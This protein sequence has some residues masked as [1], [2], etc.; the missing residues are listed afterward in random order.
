MTPCK[1]SNGRDFTADNHINGEFAP[2]NADGQHVLAHELVHT[3]QQTGGAVSMLPQDD[4]GLEID[5][6]PRLEQEAEE[7]AQRVMSGGELG[8]QRL[9]QTEVHIQ[10]LPGDELVSKTK[11]LVGTS[12]EKV[13]ESTTKRY[14]LTKDQ[15]VDLVQSVETP[16]GLAKYIEYHDIDVTSRVQDASSSAVKGAT[17]GWT[18]GSMLGS[19]FGPV[20]AVAGGL[21][22]IPLGA[23]LT[24]KFGE[25]AAGEIQKVVRDVLGLNT[26]QEFGSEDR[27]GSDTEKVDF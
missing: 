17:K 21:A 10:Q 3:R 12:V 16:K 23:F 9:A 18:A 19:A 5:P 7:T 27:T 20:G 26:N 8:V 1:A 15:L 14:R 4:L 22:G 11:D 25:Q 6:D 24:T 13:D 2:S